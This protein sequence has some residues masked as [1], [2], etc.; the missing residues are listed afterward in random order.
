[1]PPA[2]IVTS[3]NISPRRLLLLALAGLVVAFAAS[4]GLAQAASGEWGALTK[5]SF[6]KAGNEPGEIATEDGGPAAFAVDPATGG[7][8]VA[9]RVNE[10]EVTV[11]SEFRIERFSSEGKLEAETTIFAPEGE[12]SKTKTFA[13]EVQLAVDP[14][15]ERVYALIVYP[16]AEGSAKLAANTPAAGQLY[17]FSTAGGKLSSVKVDKGG[18]P[19]PIL[20]EA[21]LKTQSETRKEALLDPRGMAVEPQGNLFITGRID[22]AG[23]GPKIEQECRGVAQLVTIR[24]SSGAITGAQFGPRYVD[25]ERALAQLHCSSEGGEVEYADD[26][27]SSPVVTASGK[28]LVWESP[29]R[30]VK[31]EE[32]EEE[33]QKGSCAPSET[34]NGEVWEL[35]LTSEKLGTTPGGIEELRAKPQLL[36]GMEHGEELVVFPSP[37]EPD[38]NMSLVATGTGE[39][40]LYVQSELHIPGAGGNNANVTV[41]HLSEPGGTAKLEYEG[42]TGGAPEAGAAK[43]CVIPLPNLATV[44]VGGFKDTE[45]GK[46]RE[47]VVAFDVFQNGHHETE[48]ETQQFGPSAKTAA[49]ECPQAK[50]T[51]PTVKV[52]KEEKEV[53]KLA[54]GET[55]VLSSKVEGANAKRVEWKLENEE[56][57]E[58]ETIPLAPA[59][60]QTTRLEHQFSK[61]GHFKIAEVVESDDL[62]DP[63]LE[64]FVKA[65]SVEHS[66]PTV[67]FVSY[68]TSVTREEQK[69]T[70]EARVEDKNTPAT[71]Y[72][73]VLKFG[74]GAEEKGESTTGVIVAE[75]TYSSVCASCSVELEVTDP[76]HYTGTATVQVEVHEKTS[77]GGGGGNTGGNGNTGNTGNTGGNGSGGGSQQTHTPPTRAQLLA[78][79]L[80]TCM[81]EPKRKRAKCEVTA[82]KKYGSKPKRKHKKHRK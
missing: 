63:E 12:K 20:A 39:G 27:P 21:E 17:A 74:D 25:D 1:V 24:E 4:T 56:T 37:E 28:L 72:K 69:A 5:P 68:P 76:E 61:A 55:A 77:T 59:Q 38:R 48:I 49:E 9:S 14:A 7:F 73:Y 43:G 53:T 51:P 36:F 78:K 66:E 54:L 16:R 11:P 32:E 67:K 64:S 18:H 35:E 30:K 44:P 40:S 22:E 62:A 34:A 26:A 19:E 41:L 23:S 82:R 46:E 15:R 6:L 65:I 81:K 42:W 29:G 57:H 2:M 33:E 58:V 70:F 79:A 13:H 3:T 71:P 10:E 45:A 47:G 31:C 60:L 80:A 75:H 52:G 8:Y 50:L